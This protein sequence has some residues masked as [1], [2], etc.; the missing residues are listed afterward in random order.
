M[1]VGRKEKCPAPIIPI[2]RNHLPRQLRGRSNPPGLETR[3]VQIHQTHDQKSIII[4]I[5]V[6]LA[7]AFPVASQQTPLIAHVVQNKI[8]RFARFF[9]VGAVLQNPARQSHRADHEPVPTR[10]NFI[11]ETRLHTPLALGEKFC[12]APL[13]YFKELLFGDSQFFGENAGRLLNEQ[14]RGVALEVPLFR[15]AV[16]PAEYVGFF[17]AKNLFYLLRTPNEELALLPL[18]VCILRGIKSSSRAGHLPQNVIECIRHN[19][20]V[21]R[22]SRRLICFEVDSGQKS[23]VVKHFLEVRDKPVSI[24]AVAVETPTELIIHTAQRHSLKCYL[25]HLQ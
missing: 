17:F 4:Q 7:H 9:H 5:R 12:T 3:L 19:G 10:E 2:A 22:A 16:E 24:N 25:D 1:I 13:Q 14:G 15:D 8:R 11:V 21:K 23:V 18:A 6:E 20:A